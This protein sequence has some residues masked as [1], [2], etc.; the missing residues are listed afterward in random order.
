MAPLFDSEPP[1]TLAYHLGGVRA[2][3]EEGG[4]VEELRF[5]SFRR[6]WRPLPSSAIRSASRRGGDGDLFADLLY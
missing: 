2:T 5:R 4:R 1:L 6:S 3:F